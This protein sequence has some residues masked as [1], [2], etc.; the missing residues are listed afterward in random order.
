[1]ANFT[2]DEIA[3]LN[4]LG[5]AIN[6]N[7]PRTEKTIEYLNSQIAQQSKILGMPSFK[8]PLEKPEDGVTATHNNAPTSS[9][10]VPKPSTTS[11]VSSV[12]DI[13]KKYW[14]AILIIVAV[15]AYFVFFRKKR[16]RR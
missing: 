16:R 9:D 7:Y 13:A 1:M 15:V 8:L 5:I 11:S 12:L 6:E 3:R 4:E 2:A 10:N 14:W